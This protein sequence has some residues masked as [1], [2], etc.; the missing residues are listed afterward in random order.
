MTSASARNYYRHGRESLN[1]KTKM[2]YKFNKELDR[3]GV[4]LDH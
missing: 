2:N 1:P 3:R 4:H